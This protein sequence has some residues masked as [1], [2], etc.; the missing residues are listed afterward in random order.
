MPQNKFALARYCMIDSLLNKHE[1]VKTIYI[2]EICRR[3]LKCG[4]TQRTIQKD[5]DAM[6]N[7]PFLGYFAPIEYCS[8][9]K[10]YYYKEADFRLSPHS[11]SNKEIYL[12]QN[13]LILMQNF[14]LD[15]DYESLKN[16]VAKI[17]MFNC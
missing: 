6:K 15:D 16:I 14:I 9:R 1:Y 13:L 7:D 5:I 11:F 10:A 17:K 3:K 8:R 12:M 4:V 2:V